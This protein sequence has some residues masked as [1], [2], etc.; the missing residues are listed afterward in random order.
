MP[1]SLQLGTSIAQKASFCEGWIKLLAVLALLL[2]GGEA[3][4]QTVKTLPGSYANFRAAIT[5]I[6]A[7]F[8]AG[9]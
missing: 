2:S 1:A 8:A 4:A 7:N 6:N 5:D 9:A 3:G